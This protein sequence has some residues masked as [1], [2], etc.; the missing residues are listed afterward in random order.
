MLQGYKNPTY[1]V[2]T[3]KMRFLKNG[4]LFIPKK[5]DLSKAYNTPRQSP[6]LRARASRDS[7]K[8]PEAQHNPTTLK[9]I[10]VC[11]SGGVTYM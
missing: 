10:K 2:G 4:G 6:W 7:L 1:A 3:Y 9:Q 5:L 8:H 11:T